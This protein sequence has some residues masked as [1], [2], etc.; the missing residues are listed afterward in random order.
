M[1]VR[2]S[3]TAALLGALGAVVLLP[4][5]ATPSPSP[6]DTAR[7]GGIAVSVTDSRDRLT[8]GEETSYTATLSN[9]GDEA[10]TGLL[11]AQTAPAQLNFHEA[12]G[13]GVVEGDTVVWRIS[14]DPGQ[15]ATRTVTATLEEPVPDQDSVTTTVC[16]GFEDDPQPLVCQDDETRVVAQDGAGF[17]VRAFLTGVAIAVGIALLAGTVALALLRSRRPRGKHAVR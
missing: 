6:Q 1:I 12:D 14:L 7:N 15:E 8:V 4:T 5:E 10:V 13:G 9:E 17:P 11:V 16:A 2:N 3:A